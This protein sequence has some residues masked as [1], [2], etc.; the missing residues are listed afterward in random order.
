MTFLSSPT[1]HRPAVATALALALGLA[2][3]ACAGVPTN[4]ALDSVHQPVVERSTFTFDVTTLPG[5]GLP[6]GE[7]RRLAGWLEA[8]DLS[9]GDRVTVDDPA[10]A[11]AT[12]GAV[13]AITGRWGLLLADTAPVTGGEV[14]AGTARVV[15]SRTLASVPGCPNWDDKSDGNPSNATSRNYGCAVNGNLAAMVADK[16]DLVRGQ[17][18]TGQTV[19]M[20]A[21]K[22]ID[23]FRT[24]AP[25]G[26]SGTIK[27]VSS[28]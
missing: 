13:E 3:S 16:E 12:R 25:T 14:A 9:A 8:L 18:G 17:R 1:S 23:A 19:V 5:G 6:L 10:D 21:T 28:K 20:S 22:A 15:V 27:E 7:Q 24:R 2:L 4:R 11:P 26:A